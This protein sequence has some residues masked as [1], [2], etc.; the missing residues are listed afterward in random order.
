[1]SRRQLPRATAA[2]LD[3][4]TFL[5][6]EIAVDTTNDELRYDGDGSTVGGIALARKDGTNI[7]VTATGSATARTLADWMAGTLYKFATYAA[8]TAAAGYLVDNGIYCTYARTTEEDGGFGFWRYDSASTT[9][10]DSGTILA[11]DGG[12]A[13]RFFRLFTGAA[14]VR[15]FGAVCDATSG[16]NGTDNAAAIQLA[17]TWLVADHNRHLLFPSG[18]KTANRTYRVASTCTADWAGKRGGQITMNA[19][20]SPAAGCGDAFRLINTRELQAKLWVQ[21]GGDTIVDYSTAD[22][23]GAQQAFLI[24]GVR[25]AVLDVIGTDYDGRVVRVTEESGAEGKTSRLLFRSFITGDSGLPCGQAIY[26]DATSACATFVAASWFYDAY[27]PYFKE[28]DDINIGFLEGG[29]WT[30]SGMV[31]EGCRSIWASVIAIGDETNTLTLLTI[32]GSSTPQYAGNVWIGSLFVNDGATGVYLKDLSA[33]A[34]QTSVKIDMIV[35][36]QSTTRGVYIDNCSRFDISVHS[37]DDQI[38][39]ETTGACKNGSVHMRVRDAKR[40]ALIVGATASYLDFSGSILNAN[41]DAAATTSA[42]DVDSTGAGINFNHV[43][44]ETANADFAYDLVASNNVS[45]NYGALVLTGATVAFDADPPLV[46][47]CVVGVGTPSAA[48]TR[49]GSAATDAVG[50]FVNTTDSASVQALRIEGDRATPANSDIVYASFYLSDSAGNQTEFARISGWGTVVTDASEVGR[51]RFGVLSGG[52]ISDELILFSTAL[53][54]NANDGLA[55]GQAALAYSDL[56]LAS[57]AVIGFNNGNL[58]LTH[59]AGQITNSGIWINTGAVT[60]SS[61]TTH[62]GAVIEGVQSL[63]GAGAVDIT[64]PVTAFTSTGGAQ[65][66]TLADGVVG[67]IKK[68]VH[69]VDGGSG[70]LTPTNLAGG[71]TITFTNVAESATL[72]FLGTEWYVLA[73]QGAVLA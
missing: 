18:D 69:I 49:R 70:V 26:V 53:Y 51:L 47:R 63:S 2:Q 13:G 56:F 22:P 21:F 8:M 48:V 16:S 19:P 9:T 59:A 20:I 55:L 57:G 24:R 39:I 3:A 71:S 6:G 1:M 44:I 72:Q 25:S 35:S 32:K 40:Q 27:G 42:V 7:S 12:G 34:D 30:N 68:I 73:L 4:A 41:T 64:S 50:V 66:L 37:V 52:S 65:A 46:S 38:A 67:Q 23:V 33:D 45:L 11:I 58:T 10:A 5:P 43:S 61:T 14:D 60:H 62:T 36:R 17:F 28:T 15:W 29:H 54:P 31:I